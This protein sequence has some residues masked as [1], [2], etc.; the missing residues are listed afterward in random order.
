M[1]EVDETTHM[2]LF[3]SLSAAPKAVQA[4]S[5]LYMHTGQNLQLVRTKRRWC[6][7]AH[8]QAMLLLVLLTRALRPQEF[9]RSELVATN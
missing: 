2:S 1:P 4:I 9:M 7:S 6:R 8:S 3:C 5:T